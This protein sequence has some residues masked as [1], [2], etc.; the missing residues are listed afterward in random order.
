MEATGIIFQ[1]KKIKR[2]K[3]QDHLGKRRYIFS[4]EEQKGYLL[5][6]EI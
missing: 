2:M 3:Q 5:W 1:S 6:K 4:T